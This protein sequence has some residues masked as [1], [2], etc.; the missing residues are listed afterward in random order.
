MPMMRCKRGLQKPVDKIRK[1]KVLI[2]E[3]VDECNFF[4]VLLNHMSIT[5]VEIH[6]MGGIKQFNKNM[7]ALIS[8]R[9]FDNVHTI[10]IVRD[11]ETSHQGAFSSV[12]SCMS[13]LGYS[14][15][16]SVE[17]FTSGNPKIG[18]FITPGNLSNG[19]LEDLC[20]STVSDHPIMQD[21]DKFLHKVMTKL[22]PCPNNSSKAKNQ[23]FLSAMPEIV[24]NAG[25][26]AKKGYWDFDSSTLNDLK[27]F[28][29][30][31]R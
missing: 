3:G 30:N 2:V 8:A 22:D 10:G 26:G 11:A 4:E 19:M 31:L 23:I 16:T 17:T 9:G 12:C 28:L 14:V 21:V 15:P 24:C 5:D 20:L 13:K 1:N 18:I 27:T 7:P 6:D 29:E 25:L